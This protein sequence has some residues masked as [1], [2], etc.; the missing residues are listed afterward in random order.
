M[1]I[2][3]KIIIATIVSM[4]GKTPKTGSLKRKR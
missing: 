4:L 3:A 1:A 2:I